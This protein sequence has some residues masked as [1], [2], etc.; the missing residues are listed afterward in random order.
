MS[1][2]KGGELVRVPLVKAWGMGV[3]SMS[4]GGGTRHGASL[5]TWHAYMPCCC[6]DVVSCAAVLQHLGI[7]SN[8]TRIAGT[9]GG[10]AVSAMTCAGVPAQKQYNA[11]L[12]FAQLCRARNNCQEFL[13]SG[14]N[15]SLSQ[16]IPENA[17]EPC[18][19]RL[20]ISITAAKPDNISDE[21]VLVGGN[22]TNQREIVDAVRLSSFIPAVSALAATLDLPD[23]PSVGPAYDGGFTQSLPCPPGTCCLVVAKQWSIAV[24]SLAALPL[25]LLVHSRSLARAAEPHHVLLLGSTTAII[26]A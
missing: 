23:V 1:P 14:F 16:N 21:N 24:I 22:W 3:T 7:I 13:D 15:T 9:S 26:A 5:D 25:T 4:W 20:W 17:A 2:V 10:S 18:T 19:G 11:S 8:S 12:E 6:L